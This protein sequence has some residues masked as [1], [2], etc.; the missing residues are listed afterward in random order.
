MNE[1]EWTVLAKNL[2]LVAWLGLGRFS[3][4]G[5]ITVLKIQMEICRD[6]GGLKI[7]SF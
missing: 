5:Y 6:G 3:V 2:I 1:N 4:D 7:G